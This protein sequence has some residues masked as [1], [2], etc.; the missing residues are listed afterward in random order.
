MAHVDVR[1]ELE[2]ALKA[3]QAQNFEEVIERC[4]GVIKTA[5]NSADAFHLLGVA[6]HK[7]GNDN[8]ALHYIR[9]AIQ[10]DPQ[11]AQ[12]YNSLGLIYAEQDMSANAMQNFQ[13][14]I[15]IDSSFTDAYHN[16]AIVM[17]KEGEGE[18]AYELMQKAVKINPDNLRI[19]GYFRELINTH[20][21]PLKVVNGMLQILGLFENKIMAHLILSDI[22]YKLGRFQIA[23]NNLNRV[24][25]LD[26]NNLRA[27]LNLGTLYLETGDNEKAS[28][29][30]KKVIDL[31][32]ADSDAHYNYSHTRKFNK[33]DEEINILKDLINQ[34]GL[35]DRQ[36]INY[37]FALA[38]IHNDIGEYDKAFSYYKAGNDLKGGTYDYK[39]AEEFLDQIKSVFTK[40]FLA[41]F[42]DLEESKPSPIFIIGTPRS[43]TTLVEQIIASHPGVFPAGETTAVPDCKTIFNRFDKG[44]YPEAVL[45]L[46][47]SEFKKLATHY[48]QYVTVQQNYKNK[49]IIT[50]KFLGNAFHLGLI[51]LMFPKAKI[52]YCQRNPMAAG[53]SIYKQ[54]FVHDVGYENNLQAIA[55]Y[56]DIYHRFMQ[57]WQEVLPIKIFNLRYEDLV[58]E[59]EP[60][61]RQLVEFCQL[62][63]DDAC[64]NFYEN[65]R[66]VQTASVGQV[67]KPIYKGAI[68]SW[69]KYEKHLKPLQD[70]LTYQWK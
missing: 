28:E 15:K 3:F 53:L 52:I 68:D 17:M 42:R 13:K 41:S 49:G 55:Q 18:E 48:Y 31:R 4:E 34:K 67:H 6:T 10:K 20:K 33:D 70:A 62:P 46:E 35:E 27:L 7:K 23:I 63:W 69:K 50:D 19:F 5:P 25:E 21:V 14:A 2:G 45:K 11:Q 38:K 51:Y 9:S 57:Y 54:R 24:L 40:D 32:G 64:L 58:E 59:Q 8:K 39:K 56:F 47:R 30:Y 65:P 26:P 16:M 43:G 36:K 29:C 37:N 12:F 22:C 1:N 44:D 60:K 61:I 66:H